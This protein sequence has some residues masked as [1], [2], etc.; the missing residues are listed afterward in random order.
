MNSG[1]ANTS[2]QTHNCLVVGDQ[3]KIMSF[4]G[5]DLALLPLN[6]RFSNNGEKALDTVRNSNA[7]FSLILSDQRLEHMT[8]TEFLQ[9][10]MTLSPASVRLLITRSSDIDVIK[11]SV[12]KGVV[13]RY[14]IKTGQEGGIADDLKMAV[15]QYEMRREAEEELAKAKAVGRQLYQLDQAHKE[16]DAEIAQLQEK[17]KAISTG[18]RMTGEEITELIYSKLEAKLESKNDDGEGLTANAFGGI[19]SDCVHHLFARFEEIAKRKG[20][21]MPKP[22]EL[23]S[24]AN[25]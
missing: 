9:Q 22:G 21:N 4:L 15:N 6:I 19:Y 13:H 11:D 10:I 5:A 3:T 24:H 12:N 23:E 1:G 17:L 7:P 14:L 8:G 2:G 16:I 25:D 18:N 20:F